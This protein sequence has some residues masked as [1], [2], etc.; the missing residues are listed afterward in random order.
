MT[1]HKLISLDSL[2]GIAAISVAFFHFI[3]GSHFNNAFTMNAWLMVDFFFVLSGFVIALNYTNKLNSTEA[4]IEY[5]V[6][7]FYR[8][9]PL[10]LLLLILFTFVETTKYFV[11]IKFGLETKN[12]AFSENNFTN[13]MYN[14]FLLHNWTN[15]T[16]TFNYPSW[17]ISAEFFTYFIFGSIV[18]LTRHSNR[19]LLT[20]LISGVIVSGYKLSE[21]GM[22]T[23][24]TAGPLRCIYS[25]LIGCL[26]YSAYC[27]IK[28]FF[29]FNQSLVL[30]SLLGIIAILI[31]YKGQKTNPYVFLTPFLFGLTIFT[32]AVTDR[33][34]ILI[35]IL[36]NR[37]LVYLGNISYGIYMIHALVWWILTQI[38][39]I[40]FKFKTFMN[41]DDKMQ[42]AIENIWLADII[43]ILGLAIII[44]LSHVSYKYFEVRFNR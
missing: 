24:N 22:G 3:T 28:N 17:S 7:R 16:L 11:E 38:L 2:R 13:F 23:D 19:L 20:V 36:E 1:K 44:G 30:A 6:K 39:T 15:Q 5:Q 37:F 8:L 34:T 14:L 41:S 4:L 43:S 10:H 12:P 40:V 29:V 18:V 21:I 26:V 32:V 9:Y 35:R 42:I 31:I 25:F 27:K 33:E